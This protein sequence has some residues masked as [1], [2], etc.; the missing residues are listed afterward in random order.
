MR[1]LI[2]IIIIL[3]VG[4]Q[5]AEAQQYP[6]SSQLAT[7]IWYKVGVTDCG[8]HRLAASEV[9]DLSG[10][11]IDGIALYGLTG[12]MMSDIN[13]DDTPNDLLPIPIAVNDNNGNGIFDGNDNL[14]FYAEGPS[15]WRYDA[16]LKRYTYQRHSY[17]N[18]NYYYV[19]SQ[20]AT[21]VRISQ[22]SA[23]PPALT[24][25][26]YTAVAVHDRDLV[27]AYGSG[28]IFVGEKFSNST[29]S[30]SIDI[31]LPSSPTSDIA[32]RYAFATIDA[33]PSRLDLSLNG[34]TN[35]N[36]ISYGDN[37]FKYS[38]TFPSANSPRLSFSLSYNPQSTQ[39]SGYLD[40]IEVN[41]SAPL[42]YNGGQQSFHF[43][44]HEADRRAIIASLA[45]STQVWDITNPTNPVVLDHD[46]L[47][48][49]RLTA[50]CLMAFA[51]SDAYS[52]VSTERIDNQNLHVLTDIDYVIV[53]HQDYL[54]QAE[55]LAQMHRVADMMNVAVVSD[56]Q[57]FNEFSS[58]KP[59]PMAIRSLMRML[60]QRGQS[61]G[62][63]P[64]YLLLFG[65]GSYDSRDIEQT[66]ETTV[67][68]YESENSFSETGSYGSDDLF[69]YLELG[70]SGL[71]SNDD[72]DI[73]IG[74]LPARTADEADHLVDKILRYTSSSDRQQPSIRGD[75]RTFVALIAD[76]ADPSSPSD[77]LFA[78]SAE[79]LALRIKAT[80]PKIN[81]DRIYA[82]AY[83]QQSGAIGSYYPDV[84]NAIKKRLDYGCLLLNY[85]G[86]GS[87]QY[88]GT[89]RYITFADIASY[90]NHDQLAFFVTSTCTYGKYDKPGG[91][92]G[93]EAFIHADGGAVGCIS[94]SRPIYHIERFNSELCTL[95][96]NP[97][98]SVG[99]ALRM[100]KNHTSVSPSIS[101]LGDPAIHL[102]LPANN[103]TVTAVNQRAITDDTSCDSVSALSQVT[104]SGVIE[105]GAGE[106]INDFD[107]TLFATIF[108][109]ETRTHTLANDNP[110]TEVSFLQ[111]KN[112]LYKG[113][114]NVSKG[115]FEY[116]F[117]VP[118]DISFDYASGKVSHYARSDYD[119]AAGSYSRLFFGGFDTTAS[120][121][122]FR[123]SIRLF[124]G[125]TNFRNGGITDAE[126]TIIALLSDSVG[127]NAVGS[128]L[129]HDITLTLDNHSAIVLND[130]YEQDINDSR[131]GQLSYSLSALE[132]GTHTIT[133]KAW[134]IY[135]YSNT[136]TLTF[137]VSEKGELLTSSLTAFPNP[138][139]GSV[140]IRADHSATGKIASA[141]LDI[142]D[143]R[144]RKVF[145]C[146][147]P[148]PEGS[149]VVGPFLW[150][151][152][153]S[154][155]TPLPPSIYIA[156]LTITTTDGQQTTLTSKIVKL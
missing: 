135:N 52:P 104:I 68:T 144:G 151:F 84:N 119:D 3:F 113:A 5:A 51:A 150:D 59:D 79:D 91:T 26:T 9:P 129:G 76:D 63:Q 13:N 73:G 152:T 112:I 21:A 143:H 33:V 142:Y 80:Q 116:S 110:G 146:T 23:T 37:Y 56:V 36:N 70:E 154:A 95:L 42:Q 128:G 35:S 31:L 145:S 88:I 17:A 114:T 124:I 117:I 6:T 10:Q 30:R 1:N 133:L 64:H 96:L 48:I 41:A 102:A 77:S 19:T 29:T 83:T 53:A 122:T 123:P 74:R 14:L 109:R 147:P 138:S 47:A 50:A 66:G 57:V 7:G 11:P 2:V 58:G 44:P 105:D 15:V 93:A 125:D 107:G 12:G 62:T 4:V 118:R 22:S 8:I 149:Y 34:E 65:K 132:P 115:H 82:D 72:I 156:R 78:H 140:A 87:M 94:A 131:C 28:R 103:V 38:H 86:H 100:A 136:A 60:W 111:Q 99:D 40:F 45:S 20:P 25:D 92:A 137:S 69:G 81:I 126:P 106:V 75:W 24:T 127:I 97:A 71:S 27:N 54:T 101:L 121:E 49:P 130:F 139:S 148:S 108:D 153:S 16:M 32:C 120:Y 46:V 18:A 155:G 43:L 61:A 98:N 67:V 141:V 89:E 39:A 134:N 55:R 90:A 85:I